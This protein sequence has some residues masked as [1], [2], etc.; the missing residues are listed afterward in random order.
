MKVRRIWINVIK[1]PGCGEEYESLVTGSDEPWKCYRCGFIF[2]ESSKPIPKQF[3][4]KK[5]VEALKCDGCGKP[6]PC[7]PKNMIA[8]P[9]PAVACPECREPSKAGLWAQH[10]IGLRYRGKW[11]KP[12]FF[13][14]KR[15]ADGLL[16]A[17]SVRDR[18]AAF[19]LANTVRLNEYSAIRPSHVFEKEVYVKLLWVKGELA[20][21][22]TYTIDGW[23]MM[24]CMH[25]IAVRSE[26]RRKGYGMLMIKDFLSSFPGDVGFESPNNIVCEI[27]VKL[28][29]VEKTDNE[30]HTKGR[31]H[32]MSGF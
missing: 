4:M 7:T 22:Y 2:G 6:I 21:F 29:E 31:V 1:C 10:L 18:V 32:F 17:R 19:L 24:P 8:L 25:M 5:R 13:M 20:G 23:W 12:G 26:Y 14:K 30:Y 27:L 15:G 16:P 9:I 28:G 3:W 11:R